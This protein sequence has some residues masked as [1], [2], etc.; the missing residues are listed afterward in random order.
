MSLLEQLIA[1]ESAV[2]DNG[3]VNYV[4]KELDSIQNCCHVFEGTINYTPEMVPIVKLESY[5]EDGED[6][7]FVEG[8]DFQKM[9]SSNNMEITD[10]IGALIDQINKDNDEKISSS[11]MAIGIPMEDTDDLYSK[12]TENPQKL[13]MRCEAAAKHADY[14]RSIM[15]TGCN[16]FLM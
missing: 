11:D 12:I 13:N 7:Y 1:T 6:I 4:V 14:M 10:G 16:I 5:L 3:S 9:L 15:D 8:K 2:Y